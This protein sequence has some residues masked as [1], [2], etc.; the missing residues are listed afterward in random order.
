M[1]Q[2]REAVN[3]RYSEARGLENGVDD[4]LPTRELLVFVGVKAVYRI[5]GILR[6]YP[7]SFI[8]A[9]ARL[10]GSRYFSMGRGGVLGAR[11][12][13]DAVSTEGINFGSRVTIDE[14][15]ILRA[16]GV[17]RNM[18]VGIQIGSQTAIGAFNF[19]HGGG[20]VEIGC[21]CLFGPYVS[22]FSENHRFDD[23]NVPIREQ[24]E[25]RKRVTI[26]DDVW[27][28]TGSVVLAGVTI[29]SHAVVAAGS[30][31]TKDLEANT[32]YAGNPAKQIRK[33]GAV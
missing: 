1:K 8:A 33:R 29:G 18:G 23:V 15:T 25:V 14:G 10:T 17:I 20:G 12:H 6:G 24:G 28:G 19:I 27:I 30:V 16:S 31:V 2:I 13:I 21:N 11:V 5:I 26:G 22:I 3:R 9:S 32:V 7:T 4:R